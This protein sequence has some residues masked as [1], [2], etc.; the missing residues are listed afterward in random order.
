MQFSVKTGNGTM[1]TSSDAACTSRKILLAQRVSSEARRGSE[2]KLSQQKACFLLNCLYIEVHDI[3]CVLLD[4]LAARLDV[5]AH[6]H[7][8][9][10][11]CVYRIV[12]C[13][14]AQ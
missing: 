2:R 6:E 13:D 5:L 1:R 12:E 9:D 10:L 4:P 3:L 11:I 7:G 8:K 14:A